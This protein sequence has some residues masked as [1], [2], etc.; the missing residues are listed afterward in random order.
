MM[1]STR[2]LY[3]CMM[4][5]KKIHAEFINTCVYMGYIKYPH[6]IEECGVYKGILGSSKKKLSRRK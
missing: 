2:Y 4:L 5:I 1:M 6:R 3:L